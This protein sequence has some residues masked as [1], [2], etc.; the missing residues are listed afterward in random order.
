MYVICINDENKPDLVLE[1]DWVKKG[2]IYSVVDMV[3][4]SM[5]SEYT[6]VFKEKRPT[7]PYFGFAGSRF[8]P[9]PF[10]AN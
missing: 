10:S 2:E 1:K 3:Q 9:F 5:F 8:I 7:P 6:M 4:K